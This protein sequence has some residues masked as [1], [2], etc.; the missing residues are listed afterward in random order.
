MMW[1]VKAALIVLAASF[2]VACGGDNGVTQPTDT[3]VLS[4]LPSPP[5]MLSAGVAPP[6]YAGVWVGQIRH[7]DCRS[8]IAGFC[9]I[10]GIPREVTL[11]LNQAGITV[12]GTMSVGGLVESILSGYI[13]EDG[14]FFGS[15]ARL[16]RSGDGLAGIKV[17]D[18]YRNS[19]LVKSDKQELTGLRKVE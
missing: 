6:N 11:R 3:A 1:T 19:V 5:R 18:I 8:S 9:R 15:G 12:T 14:A 2:A 16:E 7:T 10:N 4:Y 13:A 17:D